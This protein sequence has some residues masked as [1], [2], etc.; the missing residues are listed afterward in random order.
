[1]C[2][3]EREGE[4]ELMELDEEGKETERSGMKGRQSER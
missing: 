3:R 1:L 4:R 2:G